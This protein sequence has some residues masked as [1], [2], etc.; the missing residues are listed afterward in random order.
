VIPTMNW[1]GLTGTTTAYGFK[2][3]AERPGHSTIVGGLGHRDRCGAAMFDFA[4]KKGK[5]AL[6]AM[7]SYAV[8]DGA[9]AVVGTGVRLEAAKLDKG[10]TVNSYIH[11]CSLRDSDRAALV[12]GKTVA[13]S[14][15]KKKLEKVEWMHVRNY[16][17]LF[18]EPCAVGLSAGTST[19]SYKYIND[20]Y[21]T[22]RTYKRRFYTVS[23][24]HGAAP[25]GGKYAA[26][27]FPG[28]TASE[29]RG[30]AGRPGVKIATS[31]AAHLVTDEKGGTTICCFFGKDEIGGFRSERP[32]VVAVS[33]EGAGV[34]LTV[35]D[36]A[37][38]GGKVTFRIPVKASGQG[39]KA[40]GDGT[41]VT[42]KLDGGIPAAAELKK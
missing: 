14:D 32:L 22:A 42:M 35:Q 13:L 41:V 15:G 30:I 10:R 6:R 37:H 21:G 9:V 24:G 7:K 34:H 11:Q 16:G 19:R 31:A 18:P 26:V 3:G 25:T 1:Y 12:N 5:A 39:A 17:Y 33:A 38:R 40:D 27:I 4:V 23:V 36:P 29:I 8:L 2:V 20:R 28:V